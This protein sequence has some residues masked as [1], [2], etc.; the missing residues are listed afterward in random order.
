MRREKFEKA[1]V[2]S[3]NEEESCLIEMCGSSWRWG[4]GRGGQSQESDRTDGEGGTFCIS[5]ETPCSLV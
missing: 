4:L 3:G 5:C 2:Y 1:G